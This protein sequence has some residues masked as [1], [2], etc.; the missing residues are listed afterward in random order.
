MYLLIMKYGYVY[1]DCKIYSKILDYLC[2]H[3]LANTNQFQY[4]HRL[5]SDV[6]SPLLYCTNYQQN[7]STAVLTPVCV[8]ECH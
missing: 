4:C 7:T 5:C 6:F 8:G 2:T 1:I 3:N